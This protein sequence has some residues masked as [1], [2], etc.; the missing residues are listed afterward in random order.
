M[1]FPFVPFIPFKK[2]MVA[3]EGNF[4]CVPDHVFTSNQQVRR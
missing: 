4:L 2:R 3:E 1:T